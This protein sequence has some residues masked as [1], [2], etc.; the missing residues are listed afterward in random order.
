MSFLDKLPKPF[1]V[2]APMDDVTDTV[3]RQVIAG[4]APPDVYFTEFVNVDALQSKGREATLPRLQFTDVERPIIAQLWGKDPDN[5]RKTAQELVEMGFDGVDI[6]FGC[7]DKNV[8]R[9][10]ACSAFI[11]PANREAAGEIIQAVREGAGEHFPVS[12]KTRLGFSDI[13]YTWH[14][15]LLNQKLNMLSIHGRTKKQMSKVPANWEAIGEIRKLRDK[16]SPTTLIVG[17]GDVLNLKD[18]KLKADTYKLDG[19]MIGRGIFHD[20]YIFAADSPWGTMGKAEKMSLYAKHV[21]L[22]AKTWSNGERKTITLN[23]FCKI[24][25]NGFDGAKELREQL[26]QAKS[27]EELLG[28]LR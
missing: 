11:L 16:L 19:I 24:Y 8:V 10:G 17:N 28:L 12:V 7:P 13:D 4:T 6:N 27:A 23:K 26:M 3:F 1:F 21:E 20:P 2:L 5:F 14:E 15:F 9:N 25:I 22:F 18:G